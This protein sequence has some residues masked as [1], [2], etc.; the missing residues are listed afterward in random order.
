MPCGA[1]G[2]GS[3]F[4]GPR[5]PAPLARGSARPARGRSRRARAGECARGRSA[6]HDVAFR[7][8]A[9]RLGHHAGDACEDWH[10]GARRPA[11]RETLRAHVRG[12]D[13]RR[14]PR[15]RCA[16][17][18]TSTA[19]RRRTARTSRPPTASGSAAPATSAR[20]RSRHLLESTASLPADRPRPQPA[21]GAGG[22][23][24]EPR[25][26]G[27]AARART[28]SAPFSSAPSPRPTTPRSPS[29]IQMVSHAR[30]TFRWTGQL[31][32]G[33]PRSRPGR[34]P[35]PRR[36][37]TAGRSCDWVTRFTQ[38][39]YDLEFEPP[40]YVPLDLE[41]HVCA[42]ATT[43]GR[44]SSEAVLEALGAQPGGFFDPDS[45]IVR[46]PA[47]PQ[48]CYAATVE[49]VSGVDSVT[50]LRFARLHDDDPIRAV[51]PPRR[52]WTAA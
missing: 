49:A 47:L 37:P 3:R 32:H 36:T 28:P 15:Q 13:R 41:L 24:P 14:R 33:L 7:R 10:A 16:S 4:R 19:R 11:R 5:V 18:T 8:C 31:A 21:A 9:L 17:A 45:F 34:R 39:G 44:M 52:M 12:G 20:M 50:P 23:D 29:A 6:T 25:R 22:V 51:R 42:S 38:A 30:A 48:R 2:P 26:A 35:R 27:Q 43:S 40:R 1:P 46:R